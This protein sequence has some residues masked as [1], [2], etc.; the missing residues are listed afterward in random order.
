[1]AAGFDRDTGA[2]DRTVG[3]HKGQRRMAVAGGGGC[4]AGEDESATRIVGVG[5][6][7][8]D[9]LRCN[10]H[11]VAGLK[12][13]A[14]KECLGRRAQRRDRVGMANSDQAAAATL[15]RRFRNAIARGRRY[16]AERYATRPE[17]LVLATWG[18]REVEPE[19]VETTGVDQVETRQGNG[20][21]AGTVRAGDLYEGAS[22]RRVEELEGVSNDVAN[23]VG[24]AVVQPGDRLAD[25]GVLD[26]RRGR[27][28]TVW[29]RVALVGSQCDG[30]DR[31][32][33]RIISR[34]VA[35]GQGA[36]VGPAWAADRVT[37]WVRQANVIV[38]NT[39]DEVM[40]ARG[41]PESGAETFEVNDLVTAVEP[42]VRQVDSIVVGGNRNWDERVEWVEEY[43]DVDSVAGELQR[44]GAA[45]SHR[46]PGLECVPAGDCDPI[47]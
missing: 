8:S 20:M 13:A 28:G 45:V 44:G 18:S 3:A 10:G 23:I 24:G 37:E 40:G 4:V 9:R 22:R 30:G 7:V 36:R 38:I 31:S 27:I 46:V 43:D 34:I 15:S 41:Q 42:V 6:V 1:M 35:V 12:R 2:I 16:A 33:V 17:E 26:L 25:Q 14:G 29:V 5:A 11:V 32:W 39:D 21:R 19:G 47:S